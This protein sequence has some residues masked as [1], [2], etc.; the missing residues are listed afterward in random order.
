MRCEDLTRALASPTGAA[1]PAEVAG[2]LAACPA[3]AEWSVRAAR[4]DRIWEATRPPEPSMDALDPLWARA[5]A[6]LDALGAPAPLKLRRPARRRWAMAAFVVAQAAA[7]LLAAVVLLRRDPAGPDQL[8]GFAAPEFALNVEPDVVATVRI[9]KQNEYRVEGDD[10]SY[11]Y[12]SP[13]LPM[14]TPKDLSDAVETMASGLDIV[15]S[16]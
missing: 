3:C 4:F 2:H 6:E 14:E 13:S 15:A 9:G 10:L 5:S 11:L 12:D 16:K 8:A 7:I 1:D